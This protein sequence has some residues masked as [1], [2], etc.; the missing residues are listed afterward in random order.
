MLGHQLRMAALLTFRRGKAMR[1]NFS[2]GLLAA[3]VFAALAGY[4]FCVGRFTVGG[5]T[6]ADETGYLGLARQQQVHAVAL[7][8]RGELGYLSRLF[9]GLLYPFQQGSFVKAAVDLAWQPPPPNRLP[10]SAKPS[11]VP[12]R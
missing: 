6:G 8:S 11:V 10:P 3:G 1:K 4:L 2:R 12:V 5:A 9:P 7:V